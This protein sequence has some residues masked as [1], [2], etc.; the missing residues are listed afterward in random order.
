MPNWII[1]LFVLG[2]IAFVVF[3]AAL[4]HGGA[5]QDTFNEE[6]EKPFN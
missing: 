5:L 4:C 6:I 1:G 3:V 2:V